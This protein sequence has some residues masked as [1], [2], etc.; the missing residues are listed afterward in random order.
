[1][2]EHI[3]ERYRFMRRFYF[4][5]RISFNKATDSGLLRSNAGLPGVVVTTDDGVSG[6]DGDAGVVGS[7]GATGV[8]GDAGVAGVEGVSEGPE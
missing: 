4:S 1:M 2:I 3:F 8:D 6:T 5:P 7:V